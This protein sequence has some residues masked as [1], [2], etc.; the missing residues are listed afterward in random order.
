MQ[1]NTVTFCAMDEDIAN[2]PFLWHACMLLSSYDPVTKKLEVIDNWGFYG[3]PTTSPDSVL[4][5]MKIKIGLDVDMTGNHG[6]LRHEA[7]HDLDRGCGLN[8]VTFELTPDKFKE[9]QDK[10]QKMVREQNDAI[11]DV[12]KPLNLVESIK[13]K[14]RIYSYE[15]LSPS[16]FALEKVK[17]TNQNRDPRLK[18][19]KLSCGGMR[20]CKVQIVELLEGILTPEQ[21]ARVRGQSAAIPRL[22][23]KLEKMYLHSVGPTRTHTKS[24]GQAVLYRDQKLDPEVKLYWTFPP[25]EIETIS[26]ETRRFL[27][28]KNENVDSIKNVISQLQ[29]VEWFFKNA[30]IPAKY[31]NYREELLAIIHD[32]FEVFSILEPKAESRTDNNTWS[33]SMLSLFSQNIDEGDQD[34]MSKYDDA[35]YLLTSLYF[36]MVDG[37]DLEDENDDPDVEE[38]AAYLPEN[39]MRQ[40][41]S[42]LGRS[43]MEPEQRLKMA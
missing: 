28:I 21:V 42:I 43:Y 16:I 17:A 14:A 11:D 26:D 19:F 35:K 36:A 30:T 12:I 23:G 15:H 4:R 24:S 37:W 31:E 5:A 18:E 20:T 33:N 8:G 1:I 40:L 38:L 41:C 7:T 32:Q 29:R 6:M 27:E 34:L 2:T 25:Q 9:L 10:C 22:S 3:L 13:T 39:E